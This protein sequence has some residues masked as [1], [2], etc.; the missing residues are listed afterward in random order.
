LKKTKNSRVISFNV[1]GLKAIKT[2]KVDLAPLNYLVG[3]N[4]VG[5]SSLIQGVLCLA[6]NLRSQRPNSF[7]LQ[8]SGFSFE[9]IHSA[10]NRQY[11]GFSLGIR[12]EMLIPLKGKSD[13]S[14]SVESEISIRFGGNGSKNNSYNALGF[15]SGTKQITSEKHAFLER[16]HS[17]GFIQDLPSF[18]T[19]KLTRPFQNNPFGLYKTSNGQQIESLMTSVID[20][21]LV[22]KYLD[23]A[24]DE[25]KKV[26]PNAGAWNSTVEFFIDGTDLLAFA[27]EYID[28]TKDIYNQLVASLSK[29]ETLLPEYWQLEAMAHDN[30][31]LFSK[32]LS[33]ELY[34]HFMEGAQTFNPETNESEMGLT[35][36][37]LLRTNTSDGPTAVFNLTNDSNTVETCEALIAK[38]SMMTPDKLLQQSISVD[39]E[40]FE[41]SEELENLAEFVGNNVHYLG[42]LRSSGM[43]VQIGSGSPDPLVPVGVKG[44]FFVS[45]LLRRLDEEN[46]EKSWRVGKK[47]ENLIDLSDVEFDSRTPVERLQNFTLETASFVFGSRDQFSFNIHRLTGGL[48]GALG[49]VKRA[50]KIRQKQSSNQRRSENIEGV[51]EVSYPTPSGQLT[52]DLKVAFMAWLE[53]LEIGDS[54]EFVNQGHLGMQVKLGKDSLH[55]VGTGVSQVLPVLTICLLAKPGSVTFI[56]QPELHLHP[57]AQQKLADFFLAVAQTGRQLFIET[58]SEYFIHRARRSIAVRQG[59]PRDIQI[60]FAEQEDGGSTL[61]KAK[62]RSTGSTTYWPDGFLAESENDIYDIVSSNLE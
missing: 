38:L 39:S 51:D 58:H 19:W 30:Y 56:E 36:A 17:K 21:V 31:G 54:L 1:A 46:L 2:A 44:E 60:L 10:T 34:D 16:V 6:S 62:I 47:V 32:R 22:S 33:G 50:S 53:Y 52:F 5:K 29:L 28:W 18:S 13:S 40:W 4:S 14:H 9:S 15:E 7:Q 20:P 42:P 59:K 49:F 11:S 41:F 24:L 27:L 26:G 23:K 37:E 25:L 12:A 3:T 57:A 45:A 48:D 55:Q 43:D 61:R 35:P 8:G